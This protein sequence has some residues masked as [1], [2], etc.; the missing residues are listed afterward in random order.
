MV[1]EAEEAQ[2]QTTINQYVVAIAAETV[3]AEMAE[4]MAVAGNAAAM[5]AVM[6]APTWG[7]Q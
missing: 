5:A 2:G 3:A 4:A 1:A 7:R 6:A